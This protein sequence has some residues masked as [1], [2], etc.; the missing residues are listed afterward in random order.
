MTHTH[1]FL[2]S[3]SRHIVWVVVSGPVGGEL[4][5]DDEKE[6]NTQDKIA[7]TIFSHPQRKYSHQTPRNGQSN[8]AAYF[9]FPTDHT[10]L[11]AS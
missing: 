7:I 10:A 11:T 1:I 2:F 5:R 8:D 9:L 6:H 4:F 3:F